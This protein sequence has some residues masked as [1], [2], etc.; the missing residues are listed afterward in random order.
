MA[1]TPMMS[2]Y[3]EVKEQYK[4]CILFYRLGDFYEMFFDDAKIVSKE[5]DLVLTGRACGEGERAPMCGVPFHAAEGYITKLVSKGYRVAICEQMEDPATAKGIVKREVI[6]TI[7]PGTVTEGTYLSEERNNFFASLHI[8]ENGIGVAFCDVST[9]EL[10]ARFL[11]DG[12]YPELF[13]E[14]AAYHPSEVLCDETVP[15]EVKKFCRE[16]LGALLTE[17]GG[18]YFSFENTTAMMKKQFGD[19]YREKYGFLMDD[20]SSVSAGALLSYILETQK[21]DV[22]Y[23]QALTY[24]TENRVLQLDYFSRRNLELTE[25]MRTKE[26]KGSLLW[27][28]DKTKTSMGARLLRM[29]LERPLVDCRAIRAR[30]DAVRELM[31]DTVTRMNIEEELRGIIDIERLLT[32]VVY[33]TVSPRDFVSLAATLKRI[34]YIKEQLSIYGGTELMAIST[35]I[36]DFSELAE[37]IEN[38]MIEDPPAF[39]RD[40]GFVRKGY[41]PELDYYRGL[42][43][44][45]SEMLKKLEEDQRR[46]TGIKTL[47]LGYNKVYGYYIEVSKGAVSQVPDDYRR[48]QTLTNCERYVIGEMKEWERD[49]LTA[50]EK[51]KAIEMMFFDSIKTKVLDC[52]LSLRHVSTS[53]AKLDVYL[54]LAALAVEN[55]YVCPEVD[56]SD[57]I[58]IKDGRHPV[59][60]RCLDGGYFVPNDTLLDCTNNK[61]MIITGPNM[62]GKSTYMRQVAALVLLAQIG[63]FIPARE[64]RIGIVDRIFTRVG[65]SDDLAS[66]QSTFMLEMVEVAAILENATKNSLIIYDEIGRGTSTFDGMSIAKAVVEYTADKIG[67][68]TLFATHYHELTELENTVS[69]VVNYNVAAKKRGEEIVFLRKIVKGGSDESYGIE[70]AK[71]AGVPKAVVTRARAILKEINEEMPMRPVAVKQTADDANVSFEDISKNDVIEKIKALDINMLTP[72]E[73]ISLLYEYKKTLGS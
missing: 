69:G 5:L 68:K 53:L 50:E 22:S 36:D 40:G 64:A 6:R 58:V 48:I 28:I 49:M 57:V 46:V 19:R 9:G 61:V 60:E 32:K 52:Q 17:R 3:L 26:K 33:N 56:D 29:W 12:S 10:F 14:L 23:I 31:G 67:A 2:Q 47:K 37:Y 65:A 7:S 11:G 27:V 34:P 62:A 54:S 71:L 63:S 43:N 21:T 4:D 1:L 20:P 42:L 25:T 72:F 18:D 39:S 24:Y 15:L 44:N 59:I 35:T 30:Q 51:A 66:G 70:V 45:G 38:M 55:N 16:K 8:G 41:D 13:A 73:A